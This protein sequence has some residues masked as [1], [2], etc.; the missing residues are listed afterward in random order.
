MEEIKT[1]LYVNPLVCDVKA[2]VRRD[3]E[4]A[5]LIGCI[6]TLNRLSHYTVFSA[7]VSCASRTANEG[8]ESITALRRGLHLSPHHLPFER[9]SRLRTILNGI[10]R[11]ALE[12]VVVVCWCVV[13]VQ[14]I[15]AF[16]SSIDCFLLPAHQ[17]VLGSSTRTSLSK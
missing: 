7:L 1:H 17:K 4:C 10:Y 6:P 9:T 12:R 13:G 11:Y 16:R 5:A 3:K 2:A 15:V 8:L 14:V